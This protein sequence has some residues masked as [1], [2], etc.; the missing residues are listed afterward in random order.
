MLVSN[1]LDTLPGVFFAAR[2][3]GTRL[4]FDSH[5][6]FTELPEL[7]DRRFARRIWKGFEKALLPRIQYGYT[8]CQSISDVYRDKYGIRLAVVRNLPMACSRDP[9]AGDQGESEQPDLIIY[10]GAINMGRGLE[11]MIRT[12]TYL[13]KYRLQIFGE[14]TIM[15]DL[16]RLRDSLSL[17]NRV[18]FMGRIPFAALRVFTRQAA[19]GISLEE[20]IGLN[21]HYALPNK[22][23]DY[24][25]AQIP[26][27]VSDLPEM[28]RIVTDYGIGQVVRD[29]EPERLAGQVKEMMS[30]GELRRE[31][32]KNLRM[33]AGDLHW[34]KEAGK[35]RDVYRAAGLTFPAIPRSPG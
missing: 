23:F 20:N 28:R 16:R 15:R 7:A 10:Q 26:V 14:G 30:S 19:L 5:E 6:Y 12:M 22:L 24:I 34:E 1:D 9:V 31:W 35:L 25:Q 29:R 2:I 11:T 32:K 17:E 21:Y 33:A 13:E 3:K 18:E 4:V 27:L 8:V